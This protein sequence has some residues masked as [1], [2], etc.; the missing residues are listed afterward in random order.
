MTVYLICADVYV[1]LVIHAI[2]NRIEILTDYSNTDTSAIETV[3][4]FVISKL[5][6]V[7]Y[8][9]AMCVCVC[10]CVCFSCV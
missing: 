10:M 8:D 5:E 3:N 2:C 7:K 6:P 4:H 1:R 9:I